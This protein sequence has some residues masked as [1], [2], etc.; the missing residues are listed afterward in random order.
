MITELCLFHLQNS[1]QQV[2]NVS[3][4]KNLSN[5]YPRPRRIRI[6]SHNASDKLIL[7]R[8]FQIWRHFQVAPVW[9]RRAECAVKTI[10]LYD[11][12]GKRKKVMPI[13]TRQNI[14]RFVLSEHMK[15]LQVHRGQF[16]LI[17]Q[18]SGSMSCSS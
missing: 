17:Q 5:S 1:F 8:L 12:R 14:Y 7:S 16:I 15:C 13:C 6:V 9:G 4:S 10:K 2:L 3:R 18:H 11:I